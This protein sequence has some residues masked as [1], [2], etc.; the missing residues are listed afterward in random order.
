MIER[1]MGTGAFL[2]ILTAPDLYI[3]PDSE[4][5]RMLDQVD[6]NELKHLIDVL[7]TVPEQLALL[8]DALS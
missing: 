8:G 2:A 4:M 7:F 1:L 6:P 3:E 5:A